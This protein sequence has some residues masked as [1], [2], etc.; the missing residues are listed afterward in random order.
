MLNML[1]AFLFTNIPRIMLTYKHVYDDIV[2]FGLV[3]VKRAFVLTCLRVRLQ[4]CIAII[5]NQIVM[6]DDVSNLI[7]NVTISQ[8][9]QPM[10]IGKCTSKK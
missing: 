1:V 10:G 4:I 3:N 8:Y 2:R 6:I 5:I 9:S 7:F